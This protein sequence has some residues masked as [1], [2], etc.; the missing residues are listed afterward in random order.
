MFVAVMNSRISDRDT[1]ISAY[2]KVIQTLTDNAIFE[3][4][5]DLFQNESDVVME[6]M[7]KMVQENARAAQDQAECQ[8]AGAR[9]VRA[10]IEKA[11]QPVD[12]F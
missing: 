11:R 2:R 3:D 10:D 1:I 9:E 4:E 7:R 12:R 6:F 8:A 5:T